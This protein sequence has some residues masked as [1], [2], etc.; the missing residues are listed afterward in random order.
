MTPEPDVKDPTPIV[1][2][3][4]E[5]VAL[6]YLHGEPLKA[7]I[8]S[9]AKTSALHAQGMD[10]YRQ[11]DQQWVSFVVFNEATDIAAHATVFAPVIDFRSVQSSNGQSEIRPVIETELV[12]GDRPRK[13]ELTL[14]NR[15]QMGFRLLVG[16]SA[17]DNILIDPNKSY[18]AGVNNDQRYFDF[19]SSPGESLP[20]V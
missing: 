3:W 15:D 12:I 4:R 13:I 6:P 7:K 8:D 17:L 19:P 18:L 14:T 10:V 11:D 9:G 5:R 1:V 16:R 2:G 20:S